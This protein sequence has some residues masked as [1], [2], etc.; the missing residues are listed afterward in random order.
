[1]RHLDTT[2]INALRNHRFP[3]PLLPL[4]L[5]KVI[6]LPLEVV[7][8]RVG[9][10]LEVEGATVG[11]EVEGVG[12]KVEAK[13]RC[14]FLVSCLCGGGGCDT[15]SISSFKSV[16]TRSGTSSSDSPPPPPHQHHAPTTQV[17][18]P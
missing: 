5:A 10:E 17:P 1:M 6:A 15:I 12:A 18:P 13:V 9:V 16:Y 4:L 11:I 3:L 7:G 2:R 14:L 8:E